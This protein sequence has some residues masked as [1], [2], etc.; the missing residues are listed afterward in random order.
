VR[1]TACCCVLLLLLLRLLLLLHFAECNFPVFG[2][3]T[4]IYTIYH[5]LFVASKKDRA[6]LSLIRYHEYS[7][8]ISLSPIDPFLLSAEKFEC[9]HYRLL[10]V[11]CWSSLFPGLHHGLWNGTMKEI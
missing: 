3:Y 4:G 7:K 5:A 10:G 6:Q 11:S 2:I 9:Q 1:K 8:L